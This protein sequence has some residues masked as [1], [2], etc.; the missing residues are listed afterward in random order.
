MLLCTPDVL[1]RIAEAATTRLVVH[2]RRPLVT[3]G[4][5]FVTGHSAV[6]RAVGPFLRLVGV[7]LG[8]QQI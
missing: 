5:A 6:Q 2:G 7:L 1:T 3:A 4:G 8:G